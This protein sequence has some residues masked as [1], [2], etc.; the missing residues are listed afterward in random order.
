M[1]A[2][3]S[4]TKRASSSIH[5]LQYTEINKSHLYLSH[6]K[7]MHSNVWDGL[8]IYLNYASHV[9]RNWNAHI[10]ILYTG[11]TVVWPCKAMVIPILKIVNV[12]TPKGQILTIWSSVIF[13][14]SF[15]PYQCSIL[16]LGSNNDLLNIC[17]KNGISLT[18]LSPWTDLGPCSYV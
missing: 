16:S 1:T 13:E 3:L 4:I 12:I 6:T 11:A 15:P 14:N 9:S 17:L 7:L 8:P 10:C 2:D 18:N 5:S